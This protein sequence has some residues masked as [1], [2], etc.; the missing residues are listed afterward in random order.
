MRILSW[1]LHDFELGA[2]PLICIIIEL[3][4]PHY[5]AWIACVTDSLDSCRHSPQD[6]TQM[7]V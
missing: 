7:L 6:P 3:G 2:G 5:I 1:P 4:G